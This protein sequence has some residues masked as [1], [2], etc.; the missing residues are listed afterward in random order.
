MKKRGQFYLI[1]VIVLVV[2]FAGFITIS[3]HIKKNQNKPFEDL[4]DEIQI[5]KRKVLDYVTQTDLSPLEINEKFENFSNI[6]IE[7]IGTNKNSVFI[8]GNSTNVTFNGYRDDSEIFFDCGGGYI[9]VNEEGEFMRTCLPT[10]TQIIV[11]STNE[12][13]SFEIYS[14]QNIYYLI[15]FIYDKERFISYG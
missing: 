8:Y 9:N 7:Q 10:G 1:T 5:E 15:D 6:Y 12:S 3:N 2:V 11:N 4:S 13:Y 14:G